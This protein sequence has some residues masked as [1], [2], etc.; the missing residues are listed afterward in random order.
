MQKFIICLSTLAALAFYPALAQEACAPPQNTAGQKIVGGIA[1]TADRWPGIVSLQS[2]QSDDTYHY[3]GGTLIAPGWVLTAAHCV[4]YAKMEDGELVHYD[5]N[6]FGRILK[7]GKVRVVAN[8][9]DLADLRNSEISA[10]G[11]PIIHPEYTVGSAT[12][13]YDIALIPLAQ[14][15][16]GPT[17]TLSLIADTDG[18][19][20]SGGLLEVA[21]Y[22]L[23]KELGEYGNQSPFDER[24]STRGDSINA[25]S[26]LLREVSAPLVDTTSCSSRLAQA[27]VAS[28]SWAVQY[29][30]GAA[31]LCTGF[32]GG[33]KDSCQA[34]SGGPLTKFDENGCRYQVAL[35]SWGV[36]CA[37]ADTPG[38]YTRVSAYGGWIQEHTGPLLGVEPETVPNKDPVRASELFAELQEELSSYIASIDVDMIDSSGASTRLLEPG[39]RVDIRVKMPIAGKIAIYDYNANRQLTQLYPNE[40]EASRTDGWPVWPAGKTVSIPSDLFRFQLEASKPYGEQSVLVVIVP[41]GG[42][43]L[44]RPSDGLK[45]LE[46][47][48]EYVVRLMRKVMTGVDPKRGL[49][50]IDVVDDGG[51]QDAEAADRALRERASR[52]AMGALDYCIDSRICKT[53]AME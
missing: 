34:D 8:T 28:P 2:E 31:Q 45:A 46:N 39:D 51:T 22:G 30:V 37:R 16:T 1:A 19:A 4:Q 7:Q 14:P 36:G 11:Q 38:V 20:S 29:A 44:L 52:Y 26:I 25:P 41:E 3:C 15:M 21:G 42:V 10:A 13:G 27:M 49:T 40:D 47:P 5:T 23:L 53:D 24:L 33:G 9:S 17:A 35:V 50:R 6:S 18:I 12:L 32:P 48:V 43:P